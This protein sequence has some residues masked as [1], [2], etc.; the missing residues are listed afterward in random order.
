M[1]YP[2]A[3]NA[4]VVKRALG[5]KFEDFVEEYH[6]AKSV[7]TYR[8]PTDFQHEVADYVKKHGMK[9]ARKKYPKVSYGRI[10]QAVH[11]VARH[12]WINN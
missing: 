3:F 11:K 12:Y 6:G 7:R 10:T 4:E 5:K 9:L 8:E 1:E 2:N